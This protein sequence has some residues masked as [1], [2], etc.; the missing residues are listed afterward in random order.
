VASIRRGTGPGYWADQQA[1]HHTSPCLRQFATLVGSVIEGCFGATFAIR[2]RSLP[3]SITEIRSCKAPHWRQRSGTIVMINPPFSRLSAPFQNCVLRVW[4]RGLPSGG[5]HSRQ[6]VSTIPGRRCLRPRIRSASRP[7]EVTRVDTGCCLD[8]GA[9][10]YC[11]PVLPR[12]HHNS[13]PY[14]SRIYPLHPLRGSL[15]LGF[16]TRAH[17]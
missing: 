5:S 11:L 7:R 4:R 6:Y 1:Q 15:S 3:T 14:F 9:M 10:R 17:P 8:L 13:I 12:D 2:I 16:R